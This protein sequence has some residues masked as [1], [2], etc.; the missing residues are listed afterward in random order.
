MYI[1][2]CILCIIMSF[3]IWIHWYPMTSTNVVNRCPLF[4]CTQPKLHTAQHCT[5]L[6]HRVL[7]SAAPGW[8]SNSPRHWGR[9][10][11]APWRFGGVVTQVT[12]ILKETFV[13]SCGTSIKKWDIIA[14]IIQKA[15]IVHH[16]LLLTQKP[17]FYFLSKIRHGFRW[18]SGGYWDSTSPNH[19]KSPTMGW[20]PTLSDFQDVFSVALCGLELWGRF[21]SCITWEVSVLLMFISILPAMMSNDCFG[22]GW[23]SKPPTGFHL[24]GLPFGEILKKMGE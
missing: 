8:F 20:H 21:G 13:F 7:H 3:Y 5:G 15:I 22:D 1:Y 23:S 17:Q 19:I 4:R 11:R 9:C 12:E 24:D 14:L 10:H 18:C 2:I 16:Q 6:C